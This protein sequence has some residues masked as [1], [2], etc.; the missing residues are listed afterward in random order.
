MPLKLNV[1]LSRKVGEPNYGSR[2]ASLNLELEVDGGLVA[3]PAKLQQYIRQLFSM[4]RASLNEE[5]NGSKAEASNNE[6]GGKTPGQATNGNAGQQVSVNGSAPLR[7]ATQSQVRAIL[8][9]A[10]RRQ[11]D[12]GSFLQA[13]FQVD[14]PECLSIKEA[15]LAIDE[16]KL[17]G[18]TG[19]PPW[20]QQLCQP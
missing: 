8:A 17:D 16:L 18:I 3:D 7:S 9:I 13:R 5:L 20:R 15:S 1:G 14:R 6:S 2:G 19:G 12:I 10:N 4:I 11:I